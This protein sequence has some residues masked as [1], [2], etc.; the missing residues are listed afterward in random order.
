MRHRSRLLL[1]FPVLLGLIAL[2]VYR[3]WPSGEQC[4]AH[5]TTCERHDAR[6]P[7][8]LGTN[9]DCKK[10]SSRTPARRLIRSTRTNAICSTS[11]PKWR[12]FS[13]AVEW[14]ENFEARLRN[15]PRI[16]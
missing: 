7:A 10:N 2:A 3:L 11:P 6:T 16:Q 12:A 14:L 5:M 1:L 9:R 8:T 15:P 4:K 13:C